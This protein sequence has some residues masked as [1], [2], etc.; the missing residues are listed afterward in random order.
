ML[1]VD[2]CVDK[3]CVLA[4]IACYSGKSMDLEIRPEFDFWFSELAVRVW[5]MLIVIEWAY[6]IVGSELN[7]YMNYFTSTAFYRWGNWGSEMLC[8][9]VTYN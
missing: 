7:T 3:K 1:S 5:P 9:L 6:Y 4:T 2:S 8:C